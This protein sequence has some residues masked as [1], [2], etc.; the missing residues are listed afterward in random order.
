MKNLALYAAG[1]AALALATPASASG[2][3]LTG[4]YLQVNVN[5]LGTF[6]QGLPLTGSPPAFIHDPTG[7]GTFDPNTDYI[8]PGTP[9]DG[10]SLI[11][12]QFGFTQNDNTG[13]SGF[14]TGTVTTLV[15]VAARGYANAV[16][17][18]GGLA[19]FLQI[20]NSNFFNPGDERVLIETSIVALSD[21]TN[22]AIAR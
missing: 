16:T 14:G 10:F 21:L 22:L 8:S 3:L 9:H 15:G 6:G 12:N 13:F 20:T 5:E 7:T 17:W 1:A 19:V 18:T 11:S 4:D 2:I